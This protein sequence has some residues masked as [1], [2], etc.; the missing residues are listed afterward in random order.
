MNND[1][2]IFLTGTVSPENV[3]NLKRTNPSLREADYCNAIQKWIKLGYPVV[4]VENSNYNSV[5]LDKL[6]SEN[7]NSEYI[8]FK[9]TQSHLGKSHGE[10]EIIMHAIVTSHLIKSSRVIAKASGRQYITNAAMI[11]EE[12]TLQKPYVMAWLKQ[13]LQFAD[14]RFFVAHKDFFMVYFAKKLDII[15]ESEGIYFEHALARAVH[16]S[17]SDGKVWLPPNRYP[18]CEGISGTNDVKYQNTIFSRFKGNIIL[19]LTH[20]MLRNN[21]L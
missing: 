14:S 6:F 12:F 16:Q 18:V 13:F 5:S 15:S 21:Y 7:P 19:K 4:F 2:V 10:A 8:K 3:P 17:I 1:I 20:R 9:S 11:I